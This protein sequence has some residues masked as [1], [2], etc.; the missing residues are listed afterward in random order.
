M[1]TVIERPALRTALQA[2]ADSWLDHYRL[3]RVLKNGGMSRVYLAYD[4]YEQQEVAIKVTE[5]G[6]FDDELFVGEVRSM[7]RLNHPHILQLLD[8]RRSGKWNYIVMPYISGGTLQDRIDSQTL[9]PGDISSIFEQ[10]IDALQY[11]HSRGIIHRDIKPSNILLNGSNVFLADFG[12]ATRQR[13]EVMYFDEPMMGTP[14]YMAPE[15]YEGQVSRQGDLYALG[16]VLYQ[17]LTGNVPFDDRNVSNIYWKQK[18]TYPLPPSLLNPNLSSSLEK[19]V[20]RALE[21]EPQERFQTAEAFAL[22]YQ[23]ALAPSLFTRIA[24]TIANIFYNTGHYQY[25]QA[26]GV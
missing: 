22:A 20:L 7:S 3:L 24:D 1:N 23:K 12:I 9:S 8:A 6:R 4:T 19:V 21:K 18:T 2:T 5:N 16:A 26:Y 17:M 25:R 13:A 14:V 15:I 11:M 10:M